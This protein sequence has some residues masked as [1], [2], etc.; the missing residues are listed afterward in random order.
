MFQ[1]NALCLQYMKSPSYEPLTLTTTRYKW[2]DCSTQNG[3]LRQM[4]AGKKNPDATGREAQWHLSC[5]SACT[6]AIFREMFD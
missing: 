5:G 4:Y 6:P 2:T 1:V 3:G